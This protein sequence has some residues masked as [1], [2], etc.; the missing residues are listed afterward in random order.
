MGCEATTMR[1]PSALDTGGGGGGNGRAASPVDKGSPTA[2]K[3]GAQKKRVPRRTTV[4]MRQ[5]STRFAKAEPA[6]TYPKLDVRGVYRRNCT[7]LGIKPNSLLL[8]V[9][10]EGERSFDD[11]T[12][13]LADSAYVGAKGAQALFE[14]VKVCPNLATLSLRDNGVTDEAVEGLLLSLAAHPGLTAVDL[15]QNKISQDSVPALKRALRANPRV[16]TFELGGNPNVYGSSRRE[17]EA[18]LAFN[19]AAASGVLPRGNRNVLRDIAVRMAA[20]ARP[21][22][23][24]RKAALRAFVNGREPKRVPCRNEDGWAT[25]SVMIGAS[26]SDFHTEVHTITNKVIPELN[27]HLRRH[28]IRVVPI[29]LHQSKPYNCDHIENTCNVKYALGTVQR[30]A[31]I[32]IALRGD[33]LGWVPA[34]DE[35][36]THGAYKKTRAVATAEPSSLSYLAFTEAFT[37]H[38]TDACAPLCFAYSRHPSVVD[39][40]PEGLKHTYRSSG[41]RRCWNHVETTKIMQSLPEAMRLEGYASHFKTIDRYGQVHLCR[42]QEFEQTV[43]TDI[44]NALEAMYAFGSPEGAGGGGVSLR[45]VLPTLVVPRVALLPSDHDASIDHYFAFALGSFCGRTELLERVGAS[46]VAAARSGGAGVAGGVAAAGSRVLLLRARRGS[47]GTTLL[48]RLARDCAA[49]GAVCVRYFAGLRSVLPDSTDVRTLA[50]T[51][52]LQTLGGAGRYDGEAELLRSSKAHETTAHMWEHLSRVGRARGTV[53]TVFLDGVE[54]LTGTA[55]CLDLL[56]SCGGECRVPWNVRVVATV[57]A[58]DTLDNDESDDDA[59]AAAR[60]PGTLCG[61]LLALDPAAEVHTVPRLL[62]KERRALVRRLLAPY[63]VELTPEEETAVVR[64]PQSTRP[65]YLRLLCNEILHRSRYFSVQKVVQAAEPTLRGLLV[66]M[67]RAREDREANY[68]GLLFYGRLVSLLCTTRAGLTEQECRELLM[69]TAPPPSGGGGAAVPPRTRASAAAAAAAARSGKGRSGGGGY[70][71]DPDLSEQ[72]DAEVRATR[73]RLWGRWASQPRL[74]PG[75]IWSRLAF[76]LRPF[77]HRRLEKSAAPG[78]GGGGRPGSART[79]PRAGSAGASSSAGGGDRGLVRAHR[80]H[81]QTETYVLAFA[82]RSILEAAKEVYLPSRAREARYHGQLGRYYAGRHY[83]PE[84]NLWRKSMREAVY[85]LCKAGAWD[86][87][88]RVMRPAY[89]SHAVQLNICYEVERDLEGAVLVLHDLLSTCDVSAQAALRRTVARVTEYRCYLRVFAGILADAGSA[90]AAAGGAT[91]AAAGHRPASGAT[92]TNSGVLRIV[93]ECP[94]RSEAVAAAAVQAMLLAPPGFR[95]AE[96]V[97][98]LFASKDASYLAPHVAPFYLMRNGV[99][100]DGA[101]GCAA[102]GAAA[103]VVPVAGPPVCAAAPSQLSKFVP[104]PTHE[105]TC[106]AQVVATASCVFVWITALHGAAV[107]AAAAAGDL[108]GAAAA[109]ARKKSSQK[110]KEQA[111]A[112]A[113]MNAEAAAAAEAEAAA[114]VTVPLV[115]EEEEEHGIAMPTRGN[116]LGVVYVY[117]HEGVLRK[118]LRCREMA[119]ARVSGVCVSA[120]ERQLLVASDAWRVLLFDLTGADEDARADGVLAALPLPSRGSAQLRGCA[121]YLEPPTPPCRPGV[122]AASTPLKSFA[123][124]DSG[125]RLLLWSDYLANP[126]NATQSSNG[127][128]QVAFSPGGVKMVASFEDSSCVAYSLASERPREGASVVAREQP[129]SVSFVP[130]AST[131]VL[132]LTDRAVLLWLADTGEV[133]QRVDIRCSLTGFNNVLQLPERGLIVAVDPSTDIVQWRV[134]ARAAADDE[135][136][137]QVRVVEECRMSVA[138]VWREEAQVGPSAWAFDGRVCVGAFASG[139]VGFAD[140][141]ARTASQSR[142]FATDVPLDVAAAAPRRPVL[143][144]LGSGRPLPG[145]DGGFVFVDGTSGAPLVVTRHKHRF[146]DTVTPMSPTLD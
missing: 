141:S 16:L 97:R 65:L 57:P 109:R 47:G 113:E 108:A 40:L 138:E 139:V 46:V 102:A 145:S 11:T 71:T 126:V 5:K 131:H 34:L 63:D 19:R 33:V 103:T 36:P 142:C 45:S 68:G 98:E 122:A 37:R 143:L 22:Y 52:Y 74:L 144:P 50:A 41:H 15:S 59:E 43:Q 58:Q 7:A 42:C 30:S 110:P 116:Q 120:D 76:E 26:F 81:S 96:Q 2:R 125:G 21:S 129:T 14:A 85:H 95:L 35:I 107:A 92:P 3:R 29:D 128:L 111:A 134:T 78:G 48:A 55:H 32:Y 39:G 87:L 89:L 54:D 51:A 75:A 135:E 66:Q 90:A 64:K 80:M 115:E 27:S 8:E 62:I 56:R 124:W 146:D 101:G 1:P 73:R 112:A 49:A 31:D 18:L 23:E 88:L 91:V 137:P 82:S 12:Q 70:A 106:E 4:G 121:F 72:H 20:V 13:L 79:S 123:A 25:V 130:Q 83:V 93:R 84:T 140:L 136:A 28:R 6:A 118:C 61:A 86:E 69:M 117:S 133:L 77:V 104:I 100:L 127:V 10:A 105:A 9:L 53:V 67:L 44:F 132:T 94:Q 38:N 60:A 114:T 119:G 99:R 24:E 17:I